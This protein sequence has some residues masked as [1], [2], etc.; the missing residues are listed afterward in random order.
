MALRAEVLTDVLRLARPERG[1]VI[2]DDMHFWRYRTHVEQTLARCDC[3]YTSLIDF[4]RDSFTRYSGMVS[5]IRE[6][7]G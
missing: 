3:R 6:I 4:T 2:L 5:H 1:V 7:P